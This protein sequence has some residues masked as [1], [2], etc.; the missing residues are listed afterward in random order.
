MSTHHPSLG[1]SGLGNVFKSLSRSLKSNNKRE[2]I[3]IKA[4]VFGGSENQERLLQQ[5]RRGSLPLRASAATKIIESLQKYSISSIPE[6][7][8]MARD[9]C[10]SNVQSYIRRIALKLLKECIEL[11][12]SSISNRQMF[13]QDIIRY[14]QVSRHKLDADFDLFIDALE[15][16]TL[17]GRDIDDLCITEQRANLLNFI[18]NVLEVL[19]SSSKYLNSKDGDKNDS[20]SNLTKFIKFTRGCLKNNF[21]LLG[22]QRVEL[23]IR[24]IVGIG[25]LANNTSVVKNCIDTLDSVVFVG[26]IP[27][28]CFALVVTFLSYIHEAYNEFLPEVWNVIFKL[29]QDSS[30]QL[31]LDSVCAIILLERLQK[32]S[33]LE[34]LLVLNLQKTNTSTSS[35]LASANDPG[36]DLLAALGAIDLLKKIQ[37]LSCKEQ[38]KSIEY[39]YIG[40]FRAAQKALSYNL[41]EINSAYMRY[42]RNILKEGSKEEGEESLQIGDLLPFQLWYSSSF[43]L[44]DVM[45]LLTINTEQDLQDW[46]SI[47]NLLMEL[48]EKHALFCPMNKLIDF[49]MK[50]DRALSIEGAYF[51]LN[52]YEEEKLLLQLN[53]LWKENCWLILNAFYYENA[54]HAKLLLHASFDTVI[55]RFVLTVILRAIEESLVLMDEGGVSFEVIF[56]VFKK[57]ANEKDQTIVECLAEDVMYLLAIRAPFHFL[58]SFSNFINNALNSKVRQDRPWSLVSM[59]SFN[60]QNNMPSVERFVFAPHY[61]ESFTKQLVKVFIVLSTSDGRKA[62]EVFDILV[63]IADHA[64]ASENTSLLLIVSRCLIRLRATSEKWVYFTKPTDM[65]GLST[66][67]GRNTYD[68]SYVQKNEHKWVYPESYSYLPEEYFDRPNTNLSLFNSKDDK[69]VIADGIYVI[70]ITKWLSVALGVMTQFINWEIFSFIWAHFCSQLSNMDLF[71]YNREQILQLRM[72]VCDQLM[73]NLPPSLVLPESTTKANLQVSSLRTL[74]ALLGYHD[75]FSKQEEDQIVKALIFGLGS[76]EKTAIPSIDILTT[77]CYEI[78]LSIK[79]FLTSMLVALQTK[80][81]SAFASLHTLEFLFSLIDLPL[82]TSNFTPEESH[83]LFATIF[84]YIQYSKDAKKRLTINHEEK[85]KQLLEGQE[86]DETPTDQYTSVTP[87]LS[88]YFLSLSYMLIGARFMYMDIPEKRNIASYLIKSLILLSEDSHGPDDRTLSYLDLI[89]HFTYADLPFKIM[90]PCEIRDEIFRSEDLDFGEHISSNSWILGLGIFTI[91]TNTL[92]GQT[93]L[94]IRRPTSV[95]ILRIDAEEAHY[96][97]TSMISKAGKAAQNSYPS[98]NSNYILLQLFNNL[99]LKQKCKPLPLIDDPMTTRAIAT[100]DRIPIVKYHKVGIVYIGPNQTEEREILSNRIGSRSYHKFLDAIGRYVRLK[101]SKGIYVG[102]LDTE[103]NIDG[104]YALF[105]D[106]KFTQ[107]VFHTATLMPNDEKD[108]YYDLKKRHIGNNYVT[109]YFDESGLPFNFNTIKSQFNFLNIVISPHSKSLFHFPRM[110]PSMEDARW[111]SS[112]GM[113]TDNTTERP[114]RKFFRVKTYRKAGVPGILS[115]NHF[116]IVSEDQLPAFIRNIVLTADRFASIWHTSNNAS[117]TSNWVHRVKQIRVLKEKTV[118]HHEKLKEEFNEK[119]NIA[120]TNVYKNTAQSFLEQL[121]DNVLPNSTPKEQPPT[122]LPVAR[123]EHLSSNED[124]LYSVLEFNS[125]TC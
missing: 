30:I 62:K 71:V 100:I 29:C 20:N 110:E 87:L 50:Y 55:R 101:D 60:S 105:W 84:K 10:D 119:T 64:F 74:S 2:N 73:L 112:A 6:I 102:G 121:Q 16:L 53:P 15:S 59:G 114:S 37:F 108:K 27:K 24:K 125:Y 28:R 32:L 88:E 49:M 117:Y 43:C 61:L 34:N 63:S 52:Y 42:F 107:L 40:M 31:L 80:V 123:Y 104:E 56:E 96:G 21:V 57:S 23:L 76:W 67:F 90:N 72:I 51:V 38:K 118:A 78:P 12:E 3:Q 45:K 36:R 47:C 66:N 94:T 22:D 9:M 98:I 109:V 111:S 82:L 113:G 75:L 41:P 65:D 86:A 116:K 106:G 70:D 17:H 8:Y 26:F 69:L 4:A 91:D 97:S 68:P 92:S 44:F 83:R 33:Y 99:D 89:S 93:L 103:S 54:Q 14:C 124:E 46:R 39:A 81:T 35:V 1:N 122:S 25:T 79:K 120:D 58:R 85:R 5:L 13:F 11:S 18:E 7:W 95:S 77:C 19:G 115:T 48:N